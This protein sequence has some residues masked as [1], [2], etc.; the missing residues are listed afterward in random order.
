MEARKYHDKQCYWPFYATENLE[1]LKW[2]KLLNHI[3]NNACCSKYETEWNKNT[4][5]KKNI[6][7]NVDFLSINNKSV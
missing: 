1:S 4:F 6:K 3:S 7:K 2:Q 5:C